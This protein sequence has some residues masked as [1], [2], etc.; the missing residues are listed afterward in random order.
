[1][2]ADHH[3]EEAVEAHARGH[4]EGLVGQEGHAEDTD[5]GGDAGSHEHGVPEF[6]PVGAEARQQVGIQG[7]DV[8]HRHEGGDDRPRIS[9]RT[10]VPFSFSLKNFSIEFPFP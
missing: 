3:G 6:L 4:G 2:L 8:G 10:V 9:V 7:D 5:G 1:M